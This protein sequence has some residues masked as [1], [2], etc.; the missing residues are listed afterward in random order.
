MAK[1]EKIM[2]KLMLAGVMFFSLNQTSNAG[3]LGT[4]LSLKIIFQSSPSST[5]ET[6]GSLTETVVEPE[7]EFPS[8]NDLDIAG[9]GFN[10][11]D[12]SINAGGDFIE[13]DFSNVSSGRFSSAFENTYVLKF[14][15]DA[16]V[17]ITSAAI[18]SSVTTL[19]LAA[20][21][22]R[23]VGNELFINV[24][25]LSFNSTTFVRIDLGV[26]SESDTNQCLPGDSAIGTVSQNLEIHIPS[27]NYQSLGGLQNLWV[28]FE[29]YGQGNNGE[30]L[31]RQTEYG[32][33][34]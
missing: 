3:L 14:E 6:I 15:N 34:R 16:S 17:N 23:F 26:E 1:N 9:D 13:I 29:Y 25:S 18:D 2:K 5:V 28:D 27:L 11:V 24:E 33:N 4:E 21:D 32:V 7:I 19:G 20:S 22:V 30:L 12:V 10:L 31:W 8:V